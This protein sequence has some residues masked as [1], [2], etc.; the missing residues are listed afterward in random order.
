M[1]PSSAIHAYPPWRRGRKS[2]GCF[3]EED[4]EADDLVEGCMCCEQNIQNRGAV[5]LMFRCLD[6]SINIDYIVHFS[7]GHFLFHSFDPAN[8]H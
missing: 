7:P 2:Q 4:L 3:V 5:V 1:R 8:M 6:M